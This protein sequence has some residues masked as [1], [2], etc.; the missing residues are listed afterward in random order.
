MPRFEKLIA[1]GFLLAFVFTPAGGVF[2]KNN[3]PPWETEVWLKKSLDIIKEN[4]RGTQENSLSERDL[5]I[6]REIA[7][8]TRGKMQQQM[9]EMGG[10][11]IPDS[12]KLPEKIIY[13]F[14]TLGEERNNEA[15]A[16]EAIKSLAG[17]WK[18]N[19]EIRVVLRGLPHGSKTL[20]DAFIVGKNL[21]H[22]VDSPPTVMIDP[23]AFRKYGITQTPVILLEDKGQ[24]V[25]RAKGVIN[26]R[27]LLRE[28]REGRSGNL[29]QYGPLKSIAEKDI[30]DEIKERIAD[31]DWEQ[32]KKRAKENFWIKK[33]FLKLPKADEQFSYKIVPEFRVKEDVVN[34]Q[35]ELIAEAGQVINLLE[36]RERASFFLVIFDASD[37]EQVGFAKQAGEEAKDKWRV[38]YITTT[39]P[40]RLSGWKMW[41]DMENYFDAPVYLLNTQIV[42]SFDLRKVPVTVKP[43]TESFLVTEHYLAAPVEVSK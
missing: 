7:Y 12:E 15:A 3:S 23:K 8:E 4:Q 29:G 37:P 40:S 34:H 22:E 24:E 28:V 33:E 1:A 32:K 16:R 39:P 26:P 11:A 5:E 17:E 30:F 13:A 14:I 27:W 6:A 2:A 43:Q 10:A 38:K 20:T 25:A 19:T 9:Q 21:T 31:V 36:K 42:R 41:N 35:G 18:D